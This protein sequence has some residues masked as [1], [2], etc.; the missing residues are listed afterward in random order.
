[1]GKFYVQWT[2]LRL[3]REA[4]KHL[5]FNQPYDLEFLELF[6]PEFTHLQKGTA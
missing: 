2:E 4:V 3:D 1:M 6:E 5:S